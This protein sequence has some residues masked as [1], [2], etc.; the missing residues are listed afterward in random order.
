MFFECITPLFLSVVYAFG[1]SRVEEVF[2]SQF[3]AAK[4]ITGTEGETFAHLDIK[5]NNFELYY[6][7]CLFTFEYLHRSYPL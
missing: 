2:S 6:I 1:D 3:G 4:E 7:C 5:L